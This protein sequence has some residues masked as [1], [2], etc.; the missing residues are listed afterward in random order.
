[1]MDLT[2]WMMKH[3]VHD[4]D[5]ALAVGCT[6]PYLNRLRRGEIK[7]SLELALKV[8]D[9]TKREIEIEQLLHRTS[10]PKLP[11]G[12]IGKPRGR[13]RRTVAQRA[14]RQHEAA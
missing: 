12:E 4:D 9:F 13:P 7:P 1:M 6:R 8:W 5:V 10:R 3:D 2:T 14:S 11:A